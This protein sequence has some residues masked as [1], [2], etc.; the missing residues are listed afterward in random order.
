MSNVRTETVDLSGVEFAAALA[1]EIYRRTE[2]GSQKDIAI[3]AFDMDAQSIA[4]PNVP[5]LWS[6][7]H[8]IPMKADA[9]S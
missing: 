4:L 9:I 7:C 8:K 1:E 6:K 5:A 3:N 2:S